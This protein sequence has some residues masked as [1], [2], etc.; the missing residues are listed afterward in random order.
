MKTALIIAALFATMLVLPVALWLT[1]LI[2][3]PKSDEEAMHRH[4]DEARRKA[5][6]RL[7]DIR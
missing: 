2:R 4:V 7:D 6:R 3:P 5:R 1:T